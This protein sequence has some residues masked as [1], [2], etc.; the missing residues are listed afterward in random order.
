MKIGGIKE[1]AILFP[2]RACG[3]TARHKDNKNG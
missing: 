2:T 1:M 3:M